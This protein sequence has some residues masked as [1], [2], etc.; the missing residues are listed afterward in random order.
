VVS[1][2]TGASSTAS[3]VTL[4]PSPTIIEGVPAAWASKARANRNAPLPWGGEYGAA[5][6]V[7]F[8]APDVAKGLHPLGTAPTVTI[9]GVPARDQSAAPGQAFTVDPSFLSYTSTPIT[10]TAVLRRNGADSAGFNLKYESS[11]GPS[12]TGSW[13]SI[14]GSDRWYTQTWTI[15]DDQFTGKWGYNFSFDS[16]S[17][18]NSKYSIRSV[19]VTKQ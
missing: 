12:S 2:N 4:T 5:S 17:T 14:P 11:K 13:Y 9:D 18:S 8:E 15:G 10:I 19:T 16:D 3:S 6:S 7:S 1:P